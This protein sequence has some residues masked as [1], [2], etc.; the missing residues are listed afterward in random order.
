MVDRAKL[1][2]IPALAGASREAVTAL[3]RYAYAVSFRPEQRVISPYNPARRLIFM[4]KGL[5]ALEGVSV[6]GKQRI[7]YL[8]RPGDVIGSRFMIDTPDSGHDV[9]ALTDVE[10]IA[11][12]VG[13]LERIGQEY[14]QVLFGLTRSFVRRLDS[15][16]N[17]LLRCTTDE[18]P[19]R[20]GGV[21]LDLSNDGHGT[22]RPLDHRLPHRVLA[23]IVGASR[24]HVSAVL[25][26]L[27]ESG[28]VRRGGRGSSLQVC[29]DQLREMIHQG[30]VR[31]VA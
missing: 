5:A 29:P 20:L 8:Y 30:A 7:A 2:D 24:P 9:V 15:L 11:V 3:L 1:A 28:A 25:G 14:P 23:E 27:E 13:D 22:W 18:V 16:L 31:G 12:K 6:D 26:E 4:G 17:R 10:G 21:L 19:V